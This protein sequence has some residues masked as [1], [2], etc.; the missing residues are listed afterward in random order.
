MKMVFTEILPDG[1][2]GINSGL[3]YWQLSG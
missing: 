2:G 1:A 3:G